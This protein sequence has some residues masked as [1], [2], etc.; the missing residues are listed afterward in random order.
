MWDSKLFKTGV[1]ILL[2][3][4]IFLVGSQITFIFQPFIVAFEALFFSFLISG[5]LYYLTVPFVDWLCNHRIPRPAA[6]SVVFLLFIGLFVLLVIIV[7]PILQ[8]EFTMLAENIPEKIKEARELIEKLEDN[9]FLTRLLSL[10]ALNIENITDQIAGTVSRALTQIAVSV[11]TVVDFT[12]GIFMTIII[13]PFLLYYMLK[14]KGRGTIPDLVK[15]LAPKA[16][17]TKINSALAEMNRLL[18]AYVQGLGL[19]CL[20]VGILAYIG[21]LIIGLEYALI[22]ALFILITNVV[23]FLGPFIGAIPAVIVGV[24]ESPL[25]MLQ[26]IVVIVIVQQIESLLISPQVMGRKLALSPLAIILVVLVAGRL[27][28]LLG[29]I[30]AIPIFTVLKIIATHIYEYVKINKEKA[31]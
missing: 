12:T 21:F 9:V 23:P 15:K 17:E 29:I 7:G 10:D 25:M 19:V 16:Y 20:F 6:I 31:D 18:S 13:V 28:G 22:L 24:L 5:V 4:L 26:V 14:E 11:A 1:G 2:V 27:G 30:L 3:F 8:D